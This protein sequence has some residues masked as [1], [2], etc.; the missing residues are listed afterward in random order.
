MSMI[1]RIFASELKAIA[2]EASKFSES[3]VGG[4]LFGLWN[5]NGTPVVFLATGP[6]NNYRGYLAKYKMDIDYMKMCEKILIS[7]FGLQYLGDWHSHHKL[8]LDYPSSGDQNRLYS[9]MHNN[10]I[11]NMAE[12]IITH[13]SSPPFSEKIN[14]FIYSDTTVCHGKMVLL[15][16]EESPIRNILLNCSRF[17]SIQLSPFNLG[18]GYLALDQILLDNEESTHTK[19]SKDIFPRQKANYSTEE[20][21]L[22]STDPILKLKL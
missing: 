10:K 14:G 17:Q 15:E 19:T 4:D 2:Y 20:D 11:N 22:I 7:H 16:Q 1:F 9:I 12:I 8:N 21:P 13:V 6:G 5:A 18:D 3:E